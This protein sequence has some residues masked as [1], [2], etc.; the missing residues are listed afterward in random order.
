MRILHISTGLNLGGAETMLWRLLQARD[1]GD[2][3]G[4]ISLLEVGPTGR[5]IE[6]LGIAVR[7]LRMQRWPN[8]LKLVGLARMISEFEPDVVQTWM[9][10]ADL[11]GGLAARLA[12]GAPVA[13]GLHNST[14]DPATTHRSTRLVVAASARLSWLVPDAIVSVS[15]AAADLHASKGY[16]RRKFVLIPNGFDLSQFRPDDDDRREVRRGL[17]LSDEHVLIGMVARVDPQKDHQNFIRAAAALARR[18]PE[19]RFLLCGGPGFAGAEGATPDNAELARPI[20]EAGLSDRFFLLG[21]RDDVPRVMRAL[22]VGAL[23]SSYGEAFPLVIGEAMACG[24]PCVVTDVGDAGFLVS[25][26]G[27]VVPPRDPRALARAWEELIA[28][29]PEARQRLGRDARARVEERFSLPRIAA[30]YAALWRGLIERR[31]P[32]V[33]RP[34]A[35]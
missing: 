18:R 28:L 11:F 7:A 31:A 27:R 35:P 23:S 8:P 16:A 30:E 29:G 20:R 13:W 4:V 10:H 34:A 3:H 21:Q 24:V 1:P 17:G 6:A 32:C 33:A 2:E 25:D 12:G 5:R 26:T 19:A 22:D 9:Y 14:L 15:R